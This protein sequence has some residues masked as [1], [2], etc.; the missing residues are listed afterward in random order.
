MNAAI[1]AYA[2][3]DRP[4]ALE[5]LIALQEH[6]R[7]LHDT[8]V[9]GDSSSKVYLEELLQKLA[10][11]SGAMFIAEADGRFVGLV[12]GLIVDEPWPMETP[13]STRYGYVSDIFLTPEARG[14]GLAQVLLDAIADH[15]HRA[16]PTLTR[17]RI[18]ALAV[19]RIARRA[20]EKA[21]FTPYE[22]MYERRLGPAPL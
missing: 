20:Y 11:Q 6:E 21:G 18:N 12:A 9:P 1:R 5:A 22:V 7:A 17:L 15:L 4:A 3:A 16:D 14:V 10:A 2:D 13:A 8:R 19:N